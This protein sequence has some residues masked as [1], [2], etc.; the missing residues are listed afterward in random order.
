MGPLDGKSGCP[1]NAKLNHDGS[2]PPF[3]AETDS[4]K[5]PFWTTV[6]PHDAFSALLAHPQNCLQHLEGDRLC[7]LLCAVA[8][9]PDASGE[10]K[11]RTQQTCPLGA[12]SAR[13]NPKEGAPD[14]ENPSCIQAGKKSTKINL[15]GPEIAR[16]DGGLPREGVGVEKFVPSLKS[17]ISLV[18]EGGNLGCPGNFA[19]MSGTP[20]GVQ[21]VRAKKSSCTSSL[22]LCIR[23]TVLGGLLRP[24]S[25][26]LGRGQTMG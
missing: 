9:S 12:G 13:P 25:Q 4:P 24:W 20:G 11:T 22:P 19:G 5:T 3:S 23:L 17:L 14:T 6:S 10:Q 1:P 21:K 8:R 16:W 18:F 26:T 2:N 15:L 7:D